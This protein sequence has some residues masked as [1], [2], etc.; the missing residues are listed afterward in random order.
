MPV[1]IGDEKLLPMLAV[2]LFRGGIK[3]GIVQY[4]AVAR[5]EAMLRFTINAR[6]DDADINQAVD[7]MA[8]LKERYQLPG[9]L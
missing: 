2:D 4:P 7:L 3:A 1:F 5:G 9:A 6:H 8:S